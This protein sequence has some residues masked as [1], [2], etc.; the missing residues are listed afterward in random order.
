[1]FPQKFNYTA[2]GIALAAAVIGTY[3]KFSV[4]ASWIVDVG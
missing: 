3:H 1:M 2:L 4:I